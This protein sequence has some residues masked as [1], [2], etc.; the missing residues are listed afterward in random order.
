M[1]RNREARAVLV[2][3]RPQREDK[4]SGQIR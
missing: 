1:A 4:Q 3:T 2:A